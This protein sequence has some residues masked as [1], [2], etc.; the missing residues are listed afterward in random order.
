MAKE[1]DVSCNFIEKQLVCILPNQMMDVLLNVRTKT[2][3]HTFWEDVY[4]HTLK[5][6]RWYN[7]LR[8]FRSLKKRVANIFRKRNSMSDDSRGTSTQCIIN[9]MERDSEERSMVNDSKRSSIHSNWSELVPIDMEAEYWRLYNSRK[10]PDARARTTTPLA[11]PAAKAATVPPSSPA[12]H[13]TI[14]TKTKRMQKLAS[15]EVTTCLQYCCHHK[16]STQRTH[17]KQENRNNRN[18]RKKK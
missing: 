8:P 9:S 13:K 18:S 5:Y 15:K 1:M 4:M 10:R 2:G 11:A 14:Y 6:C 16:F 17:R 3:E 7:Q 12:I